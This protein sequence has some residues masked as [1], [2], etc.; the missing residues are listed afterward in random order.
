MDLIATTSF[1]SNNNQII[2]KST[3]YTYYSVA[4]AEYIENT[5]YNSLKYLQS[6]RKIQS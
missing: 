6:S 1:N 3:L 5:D 4:C 2:E